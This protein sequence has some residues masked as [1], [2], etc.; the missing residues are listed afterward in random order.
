MIIVV[1]PWTPVD[2][3][4]KNVQKE[5][6]NRSG[7]KDSMQHDVWLSNTFLYLVMF[8]GVLSLNMHENMQELL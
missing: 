5:L 1:L 2:L 4:V 3:P 6:K 7:S 8:R